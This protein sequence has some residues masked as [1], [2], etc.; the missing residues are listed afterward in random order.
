MPIDKYI[1]K[2]NINLIP[3]GQFNSSGFFE[4]L[5][6][7]HETQNTSQ[8]YRFTEQAAQLLEMSEYSLRRSYNISLDIELNYRISSEGI[9]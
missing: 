3:T 1:F 2:S 7:G 9:R 8:M 4:T 6:S 5:Q